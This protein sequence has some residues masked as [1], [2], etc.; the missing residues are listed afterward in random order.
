MVQYGVGV[1]TGGSGARSQ[2]FR[3][4]RSSKFNFRNGLLLLIAFF[5]LRN[6]VRNDYRKEEIQYLRDSGLSEQ[7]IERYVPTTSSERK[8]DSADL[9]EMKKDIAYLLTEVEELKAGRKYSN[10]ATSDNGRDDTLIE[11]DRMHEEKRRRNEE[12]LLRD[13]PDFKPSKRLKD[14]LK[15]LEH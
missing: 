2:I 11:M 8:V 9:E 13:H 7:Q 5:V 15:E 3:N 6:I 4:L 12:Q 1:P 10:K 14:R